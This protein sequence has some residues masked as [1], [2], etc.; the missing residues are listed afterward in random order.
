MLGLSR[1]P[2][3]NEN[4]NLAAPVIEFG[5]AANLTLSASPRFRVNQIFEWRR[6]RPFRFRL[7][8]T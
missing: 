4:G 6:S 8:L 1:P 2:L 5:C 7:R 3:L